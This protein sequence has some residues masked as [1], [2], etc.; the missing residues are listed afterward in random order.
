MKNDQYLQFLQHR[1]RELS[2]QQKGQETSEQ[3]LKK[4]VQRLLD[5]I[6]LVEVKFQ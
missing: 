4:K 2:V 1:K 5:R 3:V 6:D